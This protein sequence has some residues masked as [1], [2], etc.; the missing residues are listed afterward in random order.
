MSD[1]LTQV[2]NTNIAMNKETREKNFKFNLIRMA[3]EFNLGE[4]PEQIAE[5]AKV[6]LTFVEG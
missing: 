4:S 2:N 3:Q 1:P 6:Y 5:R